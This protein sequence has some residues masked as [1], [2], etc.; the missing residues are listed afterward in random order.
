MPLDT[1]SIYG[2]MCFSFACLFYIEIYADTRRKFIFMA[3]I[4]F[5]FIIT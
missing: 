5:P 4:D 1:S 3:Y 2:G